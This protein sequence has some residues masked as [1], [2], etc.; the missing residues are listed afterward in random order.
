MVRQASM[1]KIGRFNKQDIW[2]LCPTL[3]DSSI[4]KAFRDFIHRAERNQDPF[5]KKITSETK[6][7]EKNL[8]ILLL[9]NAF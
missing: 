6:I 1:K 3:S 5:L 8:Y 9:E 2:E 7:P 4:E